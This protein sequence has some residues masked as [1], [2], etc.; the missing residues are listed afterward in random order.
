MRLTNKHKA[1]LRRASSRKTVVK[2]AV[3]NLKHTWNKLSQNDRLV[4]A[5]VLIW[6]I[7]MTFMLIN[8]TESDSIDIEYYDD[9]TE[10][11]TERLA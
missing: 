7:T 11:E 4:L 5:M 3:R 10:S 2:P 9:V 1:T 6:V 8:S